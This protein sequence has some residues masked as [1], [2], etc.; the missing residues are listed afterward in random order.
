MAMNVRQ[1]GMHLLHGNCL[2]V[3]LGE[4]HSGKEKGVQIREESRVRRATR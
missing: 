1:P 4:V 2:G 3:H